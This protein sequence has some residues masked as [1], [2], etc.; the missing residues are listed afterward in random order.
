[1]T[2]ASPPVP[3]DVPAPDT[4][5]ADTA[6]RPPRWGWTVIARKELADHL[7][8]VRWL[9][10]LVVLGLTAAIPLYFASGEI[11]SAAAAATGAPAVFLALFT[12]G[13][14]QF[15]SGS[16]RSTARAPSGHFPACSPSRSTATT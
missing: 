2:A 13:S 14:T 15:P 7:H 12:L 6:S 16:T 10:L 3:A 5:L 11:R 4:S 1:M 9:I 8:G